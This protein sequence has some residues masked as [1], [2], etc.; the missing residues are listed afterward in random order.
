MVGAGTALAHVTVDPG[1]AAKGG[2]ATF[3]VRVPNERPNASTVA[4]TVNLPE[5]SPI[6]SV[7]VQPVAGWKYTVTQKHLAEAL[8]DDDGNRTEDV[9]S[10][11]TWTATEGNA[12]KPGEFIQFPISLGPLP[13]DADQLVFKATQTYDSSE[14]VRWIEEAAEGEAEPEHPAPVVS[15]VAGG[16]EHGMSTSSNTAP[17]TSANGRATTA[18]VVALIAAALALAALTSG[19]NRPTPPPSSS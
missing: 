7:S 4:V 12:I 16:D 14:V 19:K 17:S 15:L 3:V 5:D 6:A 8:V 9:I 2:Y 18:I 1:E 10:G 13:D 11:I